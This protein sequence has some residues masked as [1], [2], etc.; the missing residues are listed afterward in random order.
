MSKE[1][2]IKMLE[3]FKDEALSKPATDEFDA[4]YLIG[5]ATGLECAINVINSAN[6]IDN[7]E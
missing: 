1:S 2:V 6:S 5:R 4:I 7:Q 3:A